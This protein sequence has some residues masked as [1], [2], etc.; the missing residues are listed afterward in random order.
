MKRKMFY[1]I[2]GLFLSANLFGEEI[3]IEKL[4]E[5]IFK[6]YYHRGSYTT[7]MVVSYG[8]DGLLLIDT[9][10]AE[11]AE[12]VRNAILEKWNCLPDIIINT[13]EHIDHTGGNNVYGK[14]PLI[15]A[16]ALV[17]RNLTSGNYV[18][19]EFPDYSLPQINFSD[20]MTLYFNGEQIKLMSLH[21]SHSANDILVWFKKSNIL[22]IG[23]IAYNGYFPS[24]EDPKGVLEFSP[25]VQELYNMIPENI[26]M[27]PGHYDNLKKEDLTVFKKMLDTTINLVL[28]EYKKGKTKDEII[29]LKL[30]KDWESYGKGYFSTN[31]WIEAIIMSQ[32][33]EN[34]KKL[35]L[36]ELYKVYKS[37]DLNKIEAKYYE[38]KNNSYDEY[39]WI[40]GI[41][42][43]VGQKLIQKK[44]YEA[45]IVFLNLERKEY[46]NSLYAYLDFYLLGKAYAGLGDYQ[47]ALENFRNGLKL[48][49]DSKRIKEEIKKLEN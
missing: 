18:F 8:E 37:G 49:P 38:L 22:C 31:L 48:S 23:D 44:Q 2:I 19:D 4:T 45:A 33:A 17:R 29:G 3:I 25:I 12:D 7:N 46:P 9:G 20:S 41:L 35:Y 43:S 14:E 24:Y 5:K 28:T 36:D 27:V 1:L 32:E 15:I 26:L 30:L 39:F 21:G 40:D 6:V 13:H 10:Q 34:N 11:E 16:D 47:L 42:A